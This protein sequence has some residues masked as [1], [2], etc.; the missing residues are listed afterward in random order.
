M[1][2]TRKH[3]TRDG[4][5]NPDL[6]ED[7]GLMDFLQWRWQRLWQD[8]SYL[9]PEKNSSLVGSKKNKPA[10]LKTNTSLFSATWIG[11]ATTLIQIEGKNILTDPIWSERCS[12][13]PFVGPK[14]YTQ[15]GLLLKELPK[16]DFVLISHNHYDHMDLPTLKKLDKMFH[17]LFIVGLKNKQFLVR[18]GLENVIELDWWDDITRDSLRIIFTPTQHF[19]ARTPFDRNKTLWGSFVVQ[20]TH[21]SFYFAG[22]TGYFKGF[23]Q[24]GEK[25]PGLKLAILPIGAYEP[26]WFMK[27]VHMNPADAIQA[28]KDLKAEYLLPI[29]YNT[30]ILTDEP[31]DE[32]LAKTRKLFVKEPF[33]RN[34]LLDLQLGE[35]KYWQK[36]DTGEETFSRFLP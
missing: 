35:S 6:T 22:D 4:F 1:N 7:H 32:P 2:Q 24:I 21:D 25:F 11:H 31:L 12:P 36:S 29:H 13:V 18:Q 5:R 15:P 33:K 34:L 26:R 14:R 3:H 23:S 8:T 27:P 30:F 28:F 9:E 20:G 17:P 10:F 16:I 19:S